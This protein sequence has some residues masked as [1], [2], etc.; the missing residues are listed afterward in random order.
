MTLLHP[1]KALFGRLL[2][3][4]GVVGVV[5]GGLETAGDVV[6]VLVSLIAASRLEVARV[7]NLSRLMTERRKSLGW[8]TYLA[9][10]LLGLLRG[11]GVVDVSLMAT[12]NL[13]VCRH[14]GRVCSW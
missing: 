8:S 5:D 14:V 3:L 11:V 13:S 7:E 1:L 4:L 2:G 9:A 12:S 6:R 10:V